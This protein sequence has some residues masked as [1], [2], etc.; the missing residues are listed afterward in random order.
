M[1]GE[2]VL[3]RLQDDPRTRDIPVTVLSADATPG[4]IERLIASGAKA[5]LTK[6]L[7]VP[8]FLAAVGELLRV[9]AKVR[10]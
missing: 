3:A 8:E 2:D 5:Y 4:Q 1:S 7:D 10:A 9:N 6:P